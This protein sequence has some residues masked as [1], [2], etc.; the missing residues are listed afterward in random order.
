MKNKN[1]GFTKIKSLALVCGFIAF[2]P[3]VQAGTD[4][5]NQ[6][7]YEFTPYLWATGQNGTV[8]V[9]NGPGNGQTLDQSFSDIWK[10]MDMGGMAAFE[11]RYD[12]WGVLLDGIYLKVSDHG[13]VSGPNGLVSLSADG[14][15]TQQQYATAGYYRVIEGQTTVDTLA[16]LRYN[17]ISWDVNARL[18]SPLLPNTVISRNFSERKRW[19]DPYAGLRVT[20]SFDQ[21][22]SVVGYA[23]IGGASAGSNLTWQLLGGV[24]YIFNPSVVGKLGY[25][26]VSINYENDGFIYDVATSGFYVGVG[27]VW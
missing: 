12:R 22:W 4:N 1:N 24:N 14:N 15:V 20:H 21:Q 3:L 10:R 9:A 17:I 25:R 18:S 26:H 5:V 19:V 2:T 7:H 13:G 27:V 23:D 8:G 11:A 16:G 6:W